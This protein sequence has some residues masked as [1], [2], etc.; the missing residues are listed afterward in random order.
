MGSTAEDDTLL[1]VLDLLRTGFPTD[2]RK[3]PPNVRLFAKYSSQLYELDGVL[4][5]NDRIVI[6]TALRQDI[7]NILHA[8]H[9]GVDRMKA[10][11]CDA[12]YWPSMVGD[13]ERTRAEC[14]S[15]HQI[16]KSNPS[17]PPLPPADPE[18]PF[19][20]I[21]ADYF[22]H[23]GCY[24]AVVVDRYSHWPSIYKSEGNDSGSNGLVSHLRRYFERYGV[25]EEVA[26]DGSPEFTS[27]LTQTFFKN[28]QIHHRKS[29]VAFP[30]S[31]CRAELAVKEVKRII[32]DNCSPSGSLDN[33]KVLKALLSY[34]N[35][36]DPVTGFSPALAVFGRQIRDGI[37]TLRG[38]FNLHHMWK[39]KLAYRENAMAHRHDAH[40][41][42]WSEHT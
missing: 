27:E 17:Q 10:R 19:Q 24:Y 36:L 31:N 20:Q 4:M 35:T 5:L 8:A 40:H 15:C 14:I 39:E 41:A 21:A 23:M 16:S 13:I 29:S 9:Q 42:A 30:H 2:I 22:H 25:P 28:W 38:K 37:P 1:S 7:L 3:V 11:A 12:V 32:T 6:P 18:F 34:R 26:S 33:D